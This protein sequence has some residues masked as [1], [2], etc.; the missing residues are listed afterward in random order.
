MSTKAESTELALELSRSDNQ[1]HGVFMHPDTG[2]CSGE[3]WPLEPGQWMQHGSHGRL[4]AV[5]EG[6]REVWQR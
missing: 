2:W 5:Y 6:G 3:L 1:P 4:M